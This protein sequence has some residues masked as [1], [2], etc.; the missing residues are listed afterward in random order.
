MDERENRLNTIIPLL[1]KIFSCI[2]SKD[3]QLKLDSTTDS[4]LKI[5]FDN[6]SFLENISGIELSEIYPFVNDC[7]TKHLS[8]H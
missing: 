5:K 6:K 1:E 3:I 7:L 8:I 4:Q 2:Y